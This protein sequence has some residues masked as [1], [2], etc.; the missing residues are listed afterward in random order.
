MWSTSG[1]HRRDTGRKLTRGSRFL[2]RLES[3]EDRTVPSTLTVLNNHDSGAGSLRAAIAGAKSGDTIVF[4]PVLDGQ[5]IALTSG[6][7]A[8]SK[9]LDIEGSGASLLAISGNNS[10]RV[11]DVSQNQTD[12]VVTIAGLTIK[13]GLSPGKGYGGGIWNVSS[14]LNLVNDVLS[15]N[16]ARGNSGNDGDGGA[17]SNYEGATL[18]VTNCRF[19]GNRA[20]GGD[21]GNRGRAIG[22]AIA[23]EYSCTAII[24]GSLFTNNVAQGGNGVTVSSSNAFPG[25]AFGGAINSG[26]PSARLTV[27]GC[28]FIG[29]QA[30]GGSNGNGP[31]SDDTV[32]GY[33]LDAGYG[34]GINAWGTALSVSHCTFSYNQGIGG[35]NST[36]PLGKGHVCDGAGGAIHPHSGTVATITDSSF[37][38]N[39]ARG[40][41]NNT[42]GGNVFI[43]GW[44]HGGAIDNDNWID[45][46]GS[47]SLTASGLTFTDNQAVGGTGNTGVP[48]AGDGIGG[49]L[50][51]W[52]AGVLTLSNSVFQNNRAIGGAGATGQ[53]GA[54]GLGGAIAN[55][56]GATL[57]VSNCTITGNQAIGGAGGS[58]GNGGDGL[59]GG[60]YNQGNS[61]FGPSSLTI[62]GSTVTS[63]SA[64]GGAAG[65]GG[66]AG[67]GIGGGAYFADGGPS[68]LDAYTL[69]KILGNA[70]STS[71]YDVFGSF[72]I[73]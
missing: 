34:G 49:A 33:D 16:V 63:N 59:G 31:K 14:T 50:A 24:C 15:N 47:N 66:S 20:I 23:L 12:V 5:T 62:T 29:N 8:I 58:G 64:T 65:S 54:D 41:N 4:A 27:Q 73:C 68:C 71:D 2:P 6:E 51:N 1:S 11:F 26:G 42:G 46:F 10:S 61:S 25:N 69:A 72:T 28:T 7:L 36:A 60:L 57:T 22:G 18:T 48:L 40:G 19:G 56:L 32:S 30:I 45:S 17:V 44:G 43:L 67:Q 39:L 9:S 21:N 38:H 13:D 70:A 37:D 55:V 3:L 52:V 53:N 35:S